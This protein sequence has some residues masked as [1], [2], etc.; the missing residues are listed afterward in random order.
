MFK[1]TMRKTSSGFTLIE[2][3]VVIAIIGLLSTLAVVALGSA[4]QKA[5]DS[6][7]LSDLKEMQVA[8][9]LHYTDKSSYPAQ[10]EAVT[11]GSGNFACL[12]VDGFSASGCANPYKGNIPQDP[13]D[14][15][16]QYISSD[17]SSYAISATLEGEIGGLKAGTVQ[18]SPSGISN[19]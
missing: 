10:A 13:G 15:V 17:G 9:E 19:Q 3:L 18:A 5:R 2:L 14:S 16:Y 4:R 11:L 8:L 1:I 7:R 12:N 6:L